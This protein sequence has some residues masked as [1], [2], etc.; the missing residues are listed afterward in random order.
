MKKALLHRLTAL[1]L[2]VSLCLSAG[3]LLSSC[4]KSNYVRF[5]VKDYGSF[6]VELYPDV[7]PVTVENFKSLVSEGFYD[8]LTIHRVVKDFMI[9]GGDPKGDGTGGSEAKIKGEFLANG[10][11]NRLPHTEGVISM[12]RT[13]YNSASSQFFIVTETSD[14]NS[15]SL[16][17]YY[18]AFGKVVSGMDVVKA[19]AACNVMYNGSGEKSKP[20]VTVVIDKVSFCD[21]NGNS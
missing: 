9:Q 17:G 13:T 6:V 20:A 12:A 18:A 5:D 2:T 4:G 15:L 11:N 14:K 7:A 1:I 19:I 21:K 8:G 3:L 16:D 10:F